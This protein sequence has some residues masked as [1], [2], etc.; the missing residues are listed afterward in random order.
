MGFQ[1]SPGVQVSEIDL[2]TIVPSVASTPGAVVIASQWGPADERILIDS[3][4]NLLLTFQGPN[5]SNFEY[6]FTAN[7]FLGYG[8]NLQVVR[9]IASDALNS[10]A[11]GTFTGVIRDEADYETTSTGTLQS[12]DEW[13]GKYPGD[14]GNSLE[15][16]MCDG[17]QTKQALIEVT[18]TYVLGEDFIPGNTVTA[19]AGSASGTTAVVVSWTPA[20]AGQSGSVLLLDNIVGAFV[21][22]DIITDDASPNAAGNGTLTLDTAATDITLVSDFEVWPFRNLFGQAPATSDYVATRVG[23]NDEVHVVVFDKDGLWTGDPG[24]VLETFDF[25][26]KASDATKND[27]S[28][29]YY[30]DVIN[31]DSSFIWFGDFPTGG[32]NWGDPSDA[33]NVDYDE[34]GIVDSPLSGGATGSAPTDGD[35]I[36]GY[37]LFANAEEVDVSLILTGPASEAVALAVI[38]ICDD[39][40]DCI[41]FVSPEKD[42]VINNSGD[43]SNDVIDFRNQLPSTSYAVMDSGWKF[44]FDK[45]N[46]TFRFVPLN[47]DIAGLAVRTDNLADPWFSPAGFNRGQIRDAVKM[48]FNPSRIERDGLYSNGVNPVV[49]FPGQGTVLFGD[50]TLLSRPSAFD[51]INVRRL[52]IVL[53]KSIAKAAQFILFEFN[54]EFTRSQFRQ[55]VEPFLREIQGRR[56]ILDFKVVADETNNTPEVID[57]NEFVADIFIKPTRSINFIQL[58]F[59]AVRT[60]VSFSEVGG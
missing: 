10:S 48:A 22:G 42:D 50:K 47:G 18:G 51:R 34:V 6:W 19:A 17:A 11:S 30:K 16:S 49:S 44:Q 36:Q 9:A 59:I 5:A 55:L 26:S 37:D 33:L 54:D 3:E 1:L 45:F 20:A 58:N 29:A 56:G 8:N 24:T 60:G 4:R 38:G 35:I 53:E 14:L 52:F 12:A 21:D 31:E 40:R 41:A 39:R 27:G 15:V 2:T 25:L 57:R 23:S 7:N 43:E 28:K 32:N 13:I 46:D